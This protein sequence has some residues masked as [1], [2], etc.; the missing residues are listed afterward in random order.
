[1]SRYYRRRYYRR[2]ESY[3]NTY[4]AHILL[5]F[6]IL[7]FAVAIIKA[8]FTFLKNNIWILIL[9][10]AVAVVALAIYVVYKIINIKY[11]RFVSDHSIAIKRLLDLNCRCSFEEIP[12]FDMENSYDNE[13]F[14]TDISPLDYLTYKLVHQKKKVL[15][16]INS[17]E[18][19]AKNFSGYSKSIT[20][21]EFD[22][23]DAQPP[24]HFEK[25][26][27][28]KEKKLFESAIIKPKTDFTIRVILTLTN[29][30]GAFIDSKYHTFDSI[31]IKRVI[32]KLSHKNG[33][34]FTDE[35]VW[36]SIC[37][38][39]RGKVSNKIRF[40]IY[41]RDG[42]CCCRCG[43]PYDLEI[44][45]IYPISKGGKSNFENLQTLCHTCN[46]LKSNTVECGA[47]NLRAKRRTAEEIC[48]RCGSRLV[49]RNGKNGRF[50]GCPNYP[51]CKFTKSI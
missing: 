48:T 36:Q 50:Y 41:N 13:N 35:D 31:E 14:Y 38:V 40:A 27:R 42:N 21:M 43:S 4:A 10:I 18:K 5:G 23:Y 30:H 19:N 44:D 28:T 45:H 6:F 7:I 22:K 25:L 33:N 34:F 20:E 15:N 9:A 1:M 46:T 26:R 39:E 51:N 29:I 12:D 17:A 2:R 37:R 47:I 16:A 8:A 3:S 11:E 49:L 24:L 32:E